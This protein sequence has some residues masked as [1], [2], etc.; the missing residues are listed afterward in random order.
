ML[1]VSAVQQSE[2]ATHIHVSALLWISFPSRSPQSTKESSLCCTICSHQLSI[3]YIVSQCICVS[4][5]LPT[6]PVLF[7]PLVSYVCVSIYALQ[8]IQRDTCTPVFT[9]APFTITRT[10]ELY[11]YPSTDERIKKMWFIYT[12]EY[13]SAI[14]QR[15]QWQPN[16]VLLPGKSHEQRSLVGCNPW[17]CEE[18]DTT[19]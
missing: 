4:L 11:K 1:L 12:I 6:H 19:E 10:W 5:S 2:S 15:R 3:L 7:S 8:I 18:S 17:G 16:P 13:Y 9:A 14:R